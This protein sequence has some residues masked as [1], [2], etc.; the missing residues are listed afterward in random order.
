MID[1]HSTQRDVFYT[2]P[3]DLP[4]TPAGFTDRWLGLLAARVPEFQINRAPGHDAGS[5]VAKNWFYQVYGVPTATFEIGDETHRP[6]IS[7]VGRQAADAMVQAL[8][9]AEP[10][11]R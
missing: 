1:F 2:I 6:L 11:P 5:G 7:R 10:A 9:E 4:T 3:A 8:S